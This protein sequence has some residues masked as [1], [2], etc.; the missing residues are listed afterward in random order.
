MQKLY[1]IFGFALMGVLFVAC[2]K[3]EPVVE[4]IAVDEMESTNRN[5]TNP[6]HFDY[7]DC[8]DD[9]G[10]PCRL[11]NLNYSNA[12]IDMCTE[13][14]H[15][16]FDPTWTYGQ[17]LNLVGLMS[18][19]DR[20]PTSG[21]Q[22]CFIPMNDCDP[23]YAGGPGQ[24]HELVSPYAWNPH[25][26]FPG[27]YYFPYHGVI[28]FCF[29]PEGYIRLCNPDPVNPVEWHLVCELDTNPDFWETFLIAPGACKLF[30]VGS[31][32]SVVECEE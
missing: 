2:Q 4:E 22:G 24:L 16:H 32:C 17:G 26:D 15:Y 8:I 6:Y 12:E 11:V 10:C 28:P 18:D 7:T 23:A 19:F 13:W 25:P 3:D 27:S 30:Y 1:L 20:T 29:F 21:P 5:W 31:N 9:G 14:G